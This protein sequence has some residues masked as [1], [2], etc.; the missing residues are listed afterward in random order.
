MN[1]LTMLVQLFSRLIVEIGLPGSAMIAVIVFAIIGWRFT[2][3]RI[4]ANEQS[5]AS[6]QLMFKQF[7]GIHA[8]SITAF[9]ALNEAIKAITDANNEATD[10]ISAANDRTHQMLIDIR[11]I[12]E[13]LQISVA[14][15]NYIDEFSQ[16]NSALTDIREL[17]NHLVNKE[18]QSDEVV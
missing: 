12:I 7:M 18:K 14:R 15:I 6:E 17:I 9:N 11:A 4:E 10:T 16:L 2:N 8:Q 1:E 13:N 3:A 5:R